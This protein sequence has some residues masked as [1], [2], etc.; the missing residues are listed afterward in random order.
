M[1][2][3]GRSTIGRVGMVIFWGVRQQHRIPNSSAKEFGV[4]VF[5]YYVRMTTCRYTC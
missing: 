3:N 4:L 1:Y 5:C 2:Q